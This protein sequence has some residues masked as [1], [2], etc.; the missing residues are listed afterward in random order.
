MTTTIG[1]D[2][3]QHVIGPG[4][5]LDLRLPSG[6]LHLRGVDG[7]SVRVRDLDGRDVSE[8]F[9]IDATADRLSI[10]PRER[11]L[12]DLGWAL[13][14]SRREV[15][16][17]VE[18]PAAA[19]LSIDAA[20]TDIVAR[21]T[22]GQQHYR[23]ASGAIDLHEVAGEIQLDAV[24]GD[25]TVRVTGEASVSGRTV[26]GAVRIHDG[27]LRALRLATT[28]GDVTIESRL[29]GDGPFA[30]QTVSGDVT[31][32]PS[33][34]LTVTGRTITGDIVADGAQRREGRGEQ[35]IT[36]GDGATPFEFKSISGDLRIARVP[37][38]ERKA[39]DD[40]DDR[41]A[42]RLVI[43]RELEAGTIDIEAASRRLAELERET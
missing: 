1:P 18:V 35:V 3:F 31:I 32:A 11:F 26:S 7:E 20:S 13:A 37:G 42:E 22:R 12:F 39:T 43:L 34:G 27:I 8:R 40:R 10:R 29:A 24:S 28:S 19:R 4:G 17:D 14:G 5:E 25:T 38:G 21:G 41:T 6:E 9:T 23:T 33:R 36:V 15:R 2:T 30:V 16:L